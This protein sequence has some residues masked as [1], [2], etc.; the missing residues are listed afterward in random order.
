MGIQEI[1]EAGL[2]HVAHGGPSGSAR[3]VRRGLQRRVVGQVP[4]PA[5]LSKGGKVEIRNGAAFAAAPFPTRQLIVGQAAA[6]DGAVAI[7]GLTQP[8]CGQQGSVLYVQ[9]Q[10]D[11][12]IEFGAQPVGALGAIHVSAVQFGLDLQGQAGQHL[13][14]IQVGIEAGNLLDQGIRVV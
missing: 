4:Y 10:T 13:A 5:G 11:A 2:E 7:K 14:L 12:G 9:G 3:V 6:L 1:L 8:A